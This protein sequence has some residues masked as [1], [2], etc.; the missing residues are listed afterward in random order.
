MHIEVFLFLHLH[1][2]LALFCA[3]SVFSLCTADV[4]LFRCAEMNG[5]KKESM[6]LNRARDPG[7]THVI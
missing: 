7:M 1:F 2:F 5:K 6:N 3:W 4:V